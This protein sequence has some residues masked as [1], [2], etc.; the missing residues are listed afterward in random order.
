ARISACTTDGVTVGHPCCGVHDCKIPL[1][2]QRAWFCPIHSGLQFVC[3]VNDCH[4]KLEAGWRTCTDSNHRA[5]EVERR[6]KGKA[7]FVLRAR[8]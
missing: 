7:M 1:A 2:N 3:A 4:N 8:L 5:F 6:T